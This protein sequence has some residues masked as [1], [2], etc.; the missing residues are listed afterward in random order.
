MKN[1]G[2]HDSF[3]AHEAEKVLPRALKILE[4]T[5]NDMEALTIA[6]NCCYTLGKD[7]EAFEY[8]RKA[9]QTPHPVSWKNF[10]SMLRHCGRYE[11]A[12]LYIWNAR[13]AWP[14]DDLIGLTYAEE[15][16]RKGKWKK[17]WPIFSKHRWTK[18]DI[19]PR[20]KEYKTIEEWTDQDLK[21]KHLLVVTEGGTGDHFWMFRFIPRLRE[22]GANISLVGPKETAEF[23]ESHPYLGTPNEMDSTPYDYWVSMFDLPY[24]FDL[25]KPYWP[26]VYM[27]AD[28]E[29]SKEYNAFMN[30]D[31][32][33][34]H[35]RVGLCWESG[36]E[37]HV[38]NMKSMAPEQAARLLS[39]DSINWVSLQK[40]QKAPVPCVQYELKNWK[41]T[42]A[43]IDNL[44]LV[45][46]VET[47]VCVLAGAMGK[48]VWLVL[49]NSNGYLWMYGDKTEWFPSF[50]I[51]RNEGRGFDNVV[52]KV[53]EA[54]K[55]L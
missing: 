35:K 36:K 14:Q 9:S 15:L 40:E 32:K 28:P 46:T 51:F 20:T 55:E 4:D 34:S 33:E 50:T 1:F 38:R 2:G 42:A 6:G 31:F 10:A 52:S 39:I 16:I 18:H 24:R 7:D 48:P 43:V 21:G 22:L 41:D 25:E 26:G 11:E 3:E 44:D 8:F 30:I 37:G 47:A 5:P 53:A 45:I 49:G 13:R 27:W 12:F 19:E 17:A 54:L 23:L 29:R